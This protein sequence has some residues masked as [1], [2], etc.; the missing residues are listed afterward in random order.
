MSTQRIEPEQDTTAQI[1]A[2]A[3]A[4]G[5]VIRAQGAAGE[6]TDMLHS[7]VNDLWIVCRRLAGD[8]DTWVVDQRVNESLRNIIKSCRPDVELIEE[9]ES[10]LSPEEPDD[11]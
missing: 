11:G 1:I 2:C 4:N 9:S 3:K 8:T 6:T 7:G 5:L 10:L